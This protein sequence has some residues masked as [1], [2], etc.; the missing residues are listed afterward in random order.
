MKRIFNILLKYK[1]HICAITLIA[2]SL[3][4][5]FTKYDVIIFRF[6]GAISNFGVAISSFF[7][8]YFAGI[9]PSFDSGFQSSN[10]D[11]VELLPFDTADVLLRLE[12]MPQALFNWENFSLYSFYFLYICLLLFMYAI[13]LITILI[14]IES[15]LSMMLTSPAEEG[16]EKTAALK[17]YQAYIESPILFVWRKLVNFFRRFIGTWYYVVP[18]AL[19]WCFNLNI[20]SIIFEALAWLFSFPT[21]P[22]IQGLV[23]PLAA[24][25]LDLLLM[26]S[27]APW[28][29]W[30]VV[31]FLIF[32]KIRKSI[33]YDRLE[34]MVKKDM[35]YINTLSLAIMLTGTMGVSKTMTITVILLINSIMMRDKAYDIMHKFQMQFP[36]FPFLKL[37]RALLDKVKDGSI[38]GPYGARR[39]IRK[40]FI[41]YRREPAAD[42]L[43]GYTGA[44]SFNNGYRHLSLEKAL[45]EYAQAYFVYALECSEL[46]TTYGIREDIVQ[47]SI[48]N[49]PLWDKDIFKRKAEDFTKNSMYSHILD[50]DVIR[51]GEKVD[52]KNSLAGSFEFGLLGVAEY[53]KERGNQFKT[54]GMK[55]DSKEANQLNDLVSYFLKLLR[56]PSTIDYEPFARI[57]VDEQRC[58][59]LN[60]DEREL[61]DII[62]ILE[63][64][65]IKLA[66]PGFG[67]AE[68]INSTIIKWFKKF[69]G[70]VRYNGQENTL[71]AYLLLRSL[72]AF[73][74]Y[75][76]RIYNRFGY[77]ISVLQKQAGT[78]DG[79]IDSHE[80]YMPLQL[81]FSDRY[82]T[83]C[84]KSFFDEYVKNCKVGIADYPTYEG[85]LATPEE[86]KLQNSFFVAELFE[87]FTKH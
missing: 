87:T 14:M 69:W 66:M 19:I 45:N 47:R 51:L 56:H 77:F 80:F 1:F 72:A 22:S 24:F 78:L 86:L 5:T 55:A 67:I 10:I 58:M 38:K 50:F 71:P 16:G 82:S 29:V 43:F 27:G 25:L 3:M 46:V 28:P 79:K 62:N 65:D 83:D 44:Q 7:A 63:K 81:A 21:A 57:C 34:H 73:S 6:G 2:I 75:Y 26:F 8:Y 20:C 49:F 68:L 85:V 11:L 76:L 30:F 40:L 33:A 54:R 31:G 64:T 39:F 35:G 9:E 32:D 36:E 48:G 52:K 60:A 23:N 41:N 59:S 13:V 17:I 12:L 37:E 18:F 53:G 4:L 15:M 70:E 84:Y 74:N 42:A 61:F